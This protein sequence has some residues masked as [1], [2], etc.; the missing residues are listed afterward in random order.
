MYSNF[1]DETNV[2]PQSQTATYMQGYLAENAA[3]HVWLIPHYHI[4]NIKITSLTTKTAF[5]K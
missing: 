2:L 5:T 3:F 1:V 4:T